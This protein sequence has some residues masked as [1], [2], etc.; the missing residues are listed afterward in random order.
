MALWATGWPPAVLDLV[1]G[2]TGRSVDEY[3]MDD[4]VMAVK[5]LKIAR[6]DELAFCL[7]GQVEV[8]SLWCSALGLESCE[9]RR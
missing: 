5:C 6:F 4:V 1:H 2:R 9:A 7:V 8:T 3:G